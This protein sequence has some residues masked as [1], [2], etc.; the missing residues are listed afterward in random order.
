MLCSIKN[1]NSF[2]VCVCCTFARALPYNTQDTGMGEW[3]TFMKFSYRE[4]M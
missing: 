3:A 4:E 1:N 2:L